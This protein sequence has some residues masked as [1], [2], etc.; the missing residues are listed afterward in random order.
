MLRSTTKLHPTPYH[1]IAELIAGQYV[2]EVYAAE[3]GSGSGPGSGS[4]RISP[5]ARRRRG[6]V[7]PSV[8][9]C[10]SQKKGNCSRTRDQH[11]PLLRVRTRN[12]V[13]NSRVSKEQ[14]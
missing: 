12:Q 14:N 4:G 10:D 6:G 1:S 11:L 9:F 13:Q 8:V 7:V 5:I 2:D 3:T